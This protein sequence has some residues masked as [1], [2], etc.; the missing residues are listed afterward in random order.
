MKIKLKVVV[1]GNSILFA[2]KD[3]FA[4]NVLFCASYL[5]LPLTRQK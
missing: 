1:F 2:W 5:K 3:I 4:L